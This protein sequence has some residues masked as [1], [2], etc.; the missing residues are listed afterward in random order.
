M[1]KVSNFYTIIYCL[2]A[3]NLSRRAGEANWRPRGVEPATGA[4]KA[5]NPAVAVTVWG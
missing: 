3:E 4:G 1:Q 2:G 5:F